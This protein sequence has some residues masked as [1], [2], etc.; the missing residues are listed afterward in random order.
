M[1]ALATCFAGCLLLVSSVPAQ[2]PKVVHPPHYPPTA[3]ADPSVRH[4][5]VV[6]MP[7][8]L[9]IER[10]PD[11]ISVGFD[12][13]SPQSV[14]IMVGKL[15][16]IGVKYE[17]RVYGE[18]EAR[19][20]EANGGVG[21]AGVNEPINPNVKAVLTNGKAF[22]NRAQGGIPAP[23]KSYVIEEDI[24]IFETDIPAQHFSS[25]TSKKY[26]VLWENKLWYVSAG[27]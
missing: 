5:V 10:T 24:S 19:P 18:G 2:G 20:V 13:A 14:K 26:K 22:L 16:S 7:T 9:S 11:R 15:M 3:D 12:S 21:L 17:M 1:R 4:E 8:R 23:G 25:P 6:P 27:K